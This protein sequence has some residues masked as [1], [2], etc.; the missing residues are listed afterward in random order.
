MWNW[1][2][3]LLIGALA[4]G[5]AGV[6]A[7]S[8]RSERASRISEDDA[9]RQMQ[10]RILTAL[11][12]PVDLARE[13]VSL[14]EFARRIAEAT[15]L[16][17]VIDD[18]TLRDA[19]VDIDSAQLH[20]SRATVSAATALEVFLSEHDLVYTVRGEQIVVTT[21]DSADA[22]LQVVVYPLP[23]AGLSSREVDVD[24]W[25]DAVTT[26]VDVLGWDHVGGR[27]HCQAVPGALVVVQQPRDQEQ[28]RV[29]IDQLSRLGDPPPTWQPVPI[30]PA[31]DGGRLPEVL[32]RLRRSASLDCQGMPLDE[33][34]D[35]LS[36]EHEL[37]IV[38]DYKRLQDSGIDARKSLVTRTLLGGTLQ[39]LLFSVLDDFDLTVL[40]RQ[41][42]VLITTPDHAQSQLWTAAFPVHDLVA[43]PQGRDFTWLIDTITATT[44]PQSWD[45]VGGPGSIVAFSGWLLV[46][47]TYETLAE[48]ELLL[49]QL[50]RGLSRDEHPWIF[51][52]TTTPATDSKITTALEQE[53]RLD[54]LGTRLI[55]IC[56]D[57]AA[58][59]G[60]R[61]ELDVRPLREVPVNGEARLICNFP[62][63][64]LRMQLARLGA[65]QGFDLTI[66]NEA[67]LL[68]T[69]D[70]AES[71]LVTRLYDLRTLTDP[72]LG[73]GDIQWLCDLI[74]QQVA[75]Q[76]WD[77]VGGAGA[78][79]EFRGLLVV[80]Q[81]L[82]R[83]RELAG[84]FAALKQLQAT[85]QRERPNSSLWTL[86][87]PV[88]EAILRRLAEP[89]TIELCGTPLEEAAQEIARLSGLRVSL[90]RRELAAVGMPVDFPLTFA[91]YGTTLG[92]ALDR[93]LPPELGYMVHRRELVITSAGAPPKL[94][95][96]RL[97]HVARVASPER[98]REMIED[99]GAI[100]EGS[101]DDWDVRGG[102]G[103]I[104]PL[105]GG[106][107][108]VTSDAR[109]QEQV[110]DWLVEKR[111][112]IVP[113]R[114][115][116][117]RTFQR[118]R[119]AAAAEAERLRDQT[120]AEL[121]E[122]LKQELGEK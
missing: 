92:G 67:L 24:S 62:P 83:H 116:E 54:Y 12:Q 89:I 72:Q 31:W 103:T 50:R 75:A 28:V 56:A 44:Q 39:S 110:E 57:L 76:S 100:E 37:P 107:I 26:L 77:N 96:T 97:H 102:P 55:D 120:Q 105:P 87:D 8:L 34:A 49:A 73:L 106:W 35:F 42:V 47:Q 118:D 117:R 33:L 68:T 65:S 21:P 5:F 93:L 52:T 121:E 111:T 14:A 25:A 1:R 64:P 86:H 3:W 115:Q 101:I 22:G 7:W 46:S 36:Q 59:T 32:A 94:L 27:G 104:N 61:I 60:I 40:V 63:A 17:I 95:S 53:V 88:E 51:A 98:V 30:W 85:R 13:I 78:M 10:A 82:E 19:G 69:Q 66:R 99:A 81:T 80:S 2:V 119:H 29:L 18:R 45:D 58:Q 122:R 15:G 38:L 23:Q 4:A 6:A 112:G 9:E 71:R 113:Q 41:D 84:L 91:A 90:D 48:L 114:S 109:V 16:D 79:S 74:E 43:F 108:I 20:L 70:G 11:Q